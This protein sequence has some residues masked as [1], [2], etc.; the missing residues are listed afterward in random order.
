MTHHAS[1][2]PGMSEPPQPLPEA[3]RKF[4]TAVSFLV[5]TGVL[6]AVAS[7]GICAAQPCCRSHQGAP[8]SKVS[9]PA[10]CSEA[11]CSPAPAHEFMQSA[12]DVQL[13]SPQV[14]PVADL[15]VA[16]L[17]PLPV[18]ERISIHPGSPPI[19]RRLA[20]LATLLI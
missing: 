5:I 4:L 19:Q 12:K 2:P 20:T 3:M 1:G 18:P 6:P 16:S 14:A 7:S 13:H 17:R 11:N 15:L 10:C 8:V 9:R